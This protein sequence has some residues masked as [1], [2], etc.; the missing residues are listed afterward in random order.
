MLAIAQTLNW[1]VVCTIGISE[2]QSWWV[3]FGQ[4]APE[5]TRFNDLFGGVSMTRPKDCCTRLSDL[6]A[7]C[8]LHIVRQLK[9]RASFDTAPHGRSDQSVNLQSGAH[10]SFAPLYRLND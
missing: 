9:F 2:L 7:R 10:D 5:R 4:G 8:D 6:R 3:W 1:D